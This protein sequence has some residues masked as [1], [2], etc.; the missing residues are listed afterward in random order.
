MILLYSISRNGSAYPSPA[1]S[2]A[3]RECDSRHSQEIP[4]CAS[5]WRLSRTTLSM[6]QH[7][8]LIGLVPSAAVVHFSISFRHYALRVVA[9]AT[10]LIYRM[11]TTKRRS[12]GPL[13]SKF[14]KNTSPRNS[15]SASSTISLYSATSHGNTQTPLRSVGCI[16]G[17]RIDDRKGRR[18]QPQQT[19][20]GS[21]F[22]DDPTAGY[23][24]APRQGNSQ[25]PLSESVCNTAKPLERTRDQNTPDFGYVRQTRRI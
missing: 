1:R 10:R 3:R 2:A 15:S 11:R 13:I 19:L 12:A 6:L 16:A 8:S 17:P 4:A 21:L 20:Q 24:L 25:V 22:L 7:E 9:K 23:M 14:A 18:A 5:S